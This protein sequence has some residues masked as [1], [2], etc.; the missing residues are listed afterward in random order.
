MMRKQST[1]CRAKRATRRSWVAALS[2]AAVL[3]CA[4]TARA[5]NAAVKGADI[6]FDLLILRPMGL[7]ELIFGFVCFAP[8]ALFAGQAIG[9]P[10]EHFVLIPFESTFKRPLGEIEEEY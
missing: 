1:R 9:D 10:W 6:A 3:G 5:E 4:A 7:G 2:L 8:A